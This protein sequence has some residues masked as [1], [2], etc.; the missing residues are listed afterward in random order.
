LIRQIVDKL[1]NL[2]KLA[3]SN[4]GNAKTRYKRYYDRKIKTQS[5]EIGNFVYLLK[6][7]KET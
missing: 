7:E 6:G 4:L 1:T 5:Y 3:V 2:R